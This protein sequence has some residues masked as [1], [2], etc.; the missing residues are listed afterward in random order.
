[1]KRETTVPGSPGVAINMKIPGNEILK[2]INLFPTFDFQFSI[3]D[4]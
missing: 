2:M 4:L 3:F 1:M